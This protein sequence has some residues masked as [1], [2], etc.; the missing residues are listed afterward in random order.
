MFNRDRN[1]KEDILA[2]MGDGRHE[3]V[4]GPSVKVDGDFVG[5]GNVL[6]QGVVNGTLKTKGNLRVEKGA[7]VKA[8]VEAQNAVVDGS[9]KGNITIQDN[10]QVGSTAN[11]E[12]DI[13]TKVISVEPGAV[14]NGHCL[15]SAAEKNLP[16]RNSVVKKS[17][18][19]EEA[20][21]EKVL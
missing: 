21:E 9:I 1:E 4:I 16:V 8:D 13:V 3:T 19:A 17:K 2:G 10:L 5:E 6:V 15:V 12:G 14:L 11:L 7:R 18:T 20:A